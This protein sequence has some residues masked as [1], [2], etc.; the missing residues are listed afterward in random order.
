MTMMS[1]EDLSNLEWHSETR[2]MQVSAPN[3]NDTVIRAMTNV[4]DLKLFWTLC[5]RL[6]LTPANIHARQ[7]ESIRPWLCRSER[8]L[9][10]RNQKQ[11]KQRIPNNNRWPWRKQQKKKKKEKEEE[12]EEEEEEEVEREK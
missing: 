12:E 6:I 10:K 1:T 4:L 7:A 5:K 3:E 8:N 2:I 9:L 11:K